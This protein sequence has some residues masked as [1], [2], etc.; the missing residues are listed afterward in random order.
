MMEL[1]T[2]ETDVEIGRCHICALTFSSQEE[3]SKHLRAA[4][5]GKKPLQGPW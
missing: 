2:Q 3:L 1:E 5:G 4:H